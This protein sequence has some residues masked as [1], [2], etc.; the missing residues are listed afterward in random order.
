MPPIVGFQTYLSNAQRLISQ[1]AQPPKKGRAA[2][3]ERRGASC[4]LYLGPERT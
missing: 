1:D 2:A 3:E 4:G